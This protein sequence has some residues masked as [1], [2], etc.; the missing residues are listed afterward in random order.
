MDPDTAQNDIFGFF[1]WTGSGPA[2]NVGLLPNSTTPVSIATVN[3]IVN[4]EFYVPNSGGASPKATEF[5]GY[6]TLIKTKDYYVTAGTTY[7]VKLGIADGGDPMFDSVVWVKAGS[8]RFN[9]KD[10][11]GSYVPNGKCTGHCEG[12]PG[13]L[14]EIYVITVPAQ[15]GGNP[16]AI[17]NGTI[18]TNT[19]CV[20]YDW[21]PVNCTA[22][23]VPVA[24]SCTGACG[25]GDGFTQETWVVTS[26]AQHGGFC[27]HINGGI[28]QPVYQASQPVS[29]DV[30]RLLA[31]Y[32][33]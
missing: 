31:L 30:C 29:Y 10:C 33:P 7:H 15:N 18:K 6:T 3:T 12:G 21:C 14:P 2:T 28:D 20:N 16:C 11:V 5:N 23:W 9:I 25:G 24:G 17:T 26:D 4:N 1:I 27:A 19:T 13:I 22:S 8:V 32:C